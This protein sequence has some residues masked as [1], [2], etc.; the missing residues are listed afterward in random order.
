MAL[1]GKHVK[2]VPANSFTTLTSDG[3]LV[4][5]AESRVGHVPVVAAGSLG[6]PPEHNRKRH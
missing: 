4:L 3:V 2:G 5:R 6:V 1:W